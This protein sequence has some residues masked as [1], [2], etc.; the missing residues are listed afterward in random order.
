MVIAHN[1]IKTEKL[2]TSKSCSGLEN[3]FTYPEQVLIG[4]LKE[5]LLEK[6][7]EVPT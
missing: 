6:I 7:Y 1:R 5:T 2:K 3:L 4:G